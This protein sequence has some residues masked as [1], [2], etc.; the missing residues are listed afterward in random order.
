VARELE[1]VSD[2]SDARWVEEALPD[3]AKLLVGSIIPGGYSAYARILHPAFDD[4]SEHVPWRAIAE[5]RGC[6]LQSLTQWEELD[7]SFSGSSPPAPGEGSLAA[8]QLTAL[9]PLLGRATATSDDCWFAIWHGYGDFAPQPSSSV[10]F[11]ST[12]PNFTPLPPDPPPRIDVSELPTLR[13]PNREYYAFRGAL[14][15]V[16]EAQ[17]AGRWSPAWV[18]GDGPNLWW[19]NDRAWFVA[20]EIDLSSTYVGGT[21][22]VIDDI[23]DEP[24][25][26]AFEVAADGPY[27]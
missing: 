17:R 2:L 3:F 13:T 25:L 5:A 7:P 27:A 15:Q 6:E 11:A 4:K 1:G 24:L 10:M 20:S 14:H 18:P 12:D 8:E 16:F 21:H 19:P 22:V 26:E 23:L 9:L